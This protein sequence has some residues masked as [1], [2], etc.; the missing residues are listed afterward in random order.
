MDNTKSDPHEVWKP[1]EE[2]DGKY[3]VSNLGRV[4]NSS[5]GYV[6]KLG[7][8][9]GYKRINLKKYNDSKTYNRAVHRLVAQTFMPNPEN[10]PEVNHING[11]HDDNRVENLE[12]VT[13]QENFEHAVAN[14]LFEKGVERAKRLG[15]SGYNRK[16]KP[17]ALLRNS[18]RLTKEQYDY[19]VSV[20]EE[21][22]VSI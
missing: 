5:T 13:P 12:W 2:F 17:K 8:K 19:I 1:I 3:E 21:L 22:G 4:R 18:E 7:D 15:G 20:S 6:L 10:K 11:V 14:K 9:H 16:D